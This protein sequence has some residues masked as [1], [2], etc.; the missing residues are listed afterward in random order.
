MSP[1]GRLRRIWA[2]THFPSS[3]NQARWSESGANS[4]SMIV[5]RCFAANRCFPGRSLSHFTTHKSQTKRPLRLLRSPIEV[6]G[7]LLYPE[8]PGLRSWPSRRGAFVRRPFLQKGRFCSWC[9]S[10]WLCVHRLTTSLA[11]AP[12]ACRTRSARGGVDVVTFHSSVHGSLGCSA[13]H[14]SISD[15]PHPDHHGHH[16]IHGDDDRGRVQGA[17]RG[18]VCPT[19]CRRQTQ[20]NTHSETFHMACEL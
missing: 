1:S 3:V 6:A 13:C 12:S 9:P 7:S 18:R 4:T 11:M 16:H 19:R 15:Y 20:S 10:R 14:T 2:K 17:A 5:P 8:K